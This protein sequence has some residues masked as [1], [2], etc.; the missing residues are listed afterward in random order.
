MAKVDFTDNVQTLHNIGQH[1][2]QYEALQNAYVYALVNRIGRVLVTSKLWDNPLARFK[3]GILEYG[4]T[5]EEI[6]VNIARGYA[7]DPEAAEKTVFKRNIPDVRAAFHTMNFQEY[8]PVTVSEEQ[9]RQSFIAFSDVTMLIAYIVDSLYNGMNLDEFLLMKYLMAREILN[10]GFY[11]VKT[12]AISGNNAD[13]DDAIIKYRQYTNDLTYMKTKFNR[14]RVYSHT[15]IADQVIIMPNEPESILGVTVLANAFNINQVDY[16]SSR[17]PI[18]SFVFDADDEKRLQ[19]IFEQNN[20]LTTLGSY[21]PFTTAEKNALAAVNA[22]KIDADWFM[23]YDNMAPRVTENFNGKGINWNY[24][25]HVWRTFS[26][27]PFKNAVV[28]TSGTSTVTSI[29]VSPSTATLSKGAT[30]QFTAVVAGTGIYD[31][32]VVWSISGQ[33]STDTRIDPQ[34]GNLT[35]S[36]SETAT[37]ITVTAT[38]SAGHTDTATVTVQ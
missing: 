28:F 36:R 24:N 25:L 5:T 17:I 32:S 2:M 20:E 7:Y 1:I 10:G 9:L 11:V 22:V 12:A 37:S 16:I 26:C 3:K 30:M 34:N 6:F 29:T 38:D 4:E 18:D 33:N 35:I 13:P 14:A 31:K 15:P 23:V 21:T 27:S 8:Y 19:Q